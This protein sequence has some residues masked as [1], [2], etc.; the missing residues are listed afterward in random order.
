VR[1]TRK[2]LRI[3]VNDHRAASA[4]G[5]ALAARTARNNHGTEL[6]ADLRWLHAQ[7][8]EDADALVAVAER[9]VIPENPFK[10]A[11]ARVGEAVGRLKLNGWIV[12]YSPLSRLLEV[13]MLLAG[14]DAKRSLW[15]ALDAAALP[16]LH[17]IDL[18]RLIN[19]ASEQRE[20][21]VPHHDR[22]AAAAFGCASSAAR[23]LTP[24]EPR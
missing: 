20:R 13:E 23:V 19:R 11:L 18:D 22:A 24:R 15:R 4:G 17:D 5:V 8:V 16:E 9:L 14:I 10:R 12:G 2:L 6:S 7:L 21:L 1:D 3:Y